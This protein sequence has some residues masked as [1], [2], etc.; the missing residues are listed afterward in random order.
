MK[1]LGFYAA[2]ALKF[3]NHPQTDWS[4]KT[5]PQRKACLNSINQVRDF[6]YSSNTVRG[7]KSCYNIKCVV[8]FILHSSSNLAGVL[9]E[10]LAE[11]QTLI[12]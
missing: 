9:E 10:A 6:F 3:L 12:S 5:V 2:L 8:Q 7:I 11:L 4:H 1:N